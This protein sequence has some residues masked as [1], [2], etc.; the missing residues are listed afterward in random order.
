[1]AVRTEYQRTVALQNSNANDQVGGVPLPPMPTIEVVEN[2]AVRFDLNSSMLFE[3]NSVEL[4]PRGQAHMRVLAE[5]LVENPN[6]LVTIIGHTDNTGDA[7]YNQTL[8]ERR[9]EAVAG[10]LV[11]QGVVSRRLAKIGRGETEPA[12]TNKTELG[13]KKNRRVEIVIIP[14]ES[15]S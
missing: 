13:R 12:Y 14:T 6:S 1:M 3:V 2:R 15:A 4:Q 10:Y 9:A 7:H 5:S 8:S 11:D